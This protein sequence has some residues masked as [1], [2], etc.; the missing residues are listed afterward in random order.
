MPFA[1]LDVHKKEIEAVILDDS[2]R[3]LLRQ[4]FATRRETLEEFARRHLTDCRVALEATTNTWAIVAILAPL[5]KE[6]V[7]SNPLRTRA[8]ASAKIK[9]DKVD[10]LVLAQ[11]LRSE[12]LPRVWTPDEETRRLRQ[13][14]SERANLSA[15]RTRLK[16]RIHS[17]LHQRLIEAPMKDLFSKAGM[18]WLAP[19]ELDEAGRRALERHLRQLAQVESEFALLDDELARQAYEHPQIKLLM[20]LPGVDYA[21]AESLLAVLGDITRFAD[22]DAAACYFGLVPSTHQ[23]GSHCYHGR[24]TKQGSA[25][26]RWML[27]QAAQHVATHPGPLGVFFRRLARKKNRNVAVV[28]TARKLVTI[29]WHMLKNNEPYRY[30]QPKTVAAKYSRLRVRVTAARKR[31]GGKGQKRPATYG[32]GKRTRAVPALDQVYAAEGL[33]ALASVAAGERAMLERH[34]VADYAAHIRQSHRVPRAAP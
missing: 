34:R 24:I 8:I 17:V 6:V 31:G 23:S 30:A 29:A 27:I 3:V 15:D 19:L 12:Y 4:R 25:H 26:G 9:T 21:V 20:S 13:Q 22:P 1:G 28:A 5:V 11:L 33:P 14:T 18:N 10:D 32:T 7:V 16:N 2:G